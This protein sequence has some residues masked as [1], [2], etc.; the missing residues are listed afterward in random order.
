MQTFTDFKDDLSK[1]QDSILKAMKDPT[2]EDREE[3]AALADE[4]TQTGESI[5]EA[6]G[7]SH[8]ARARILDRERLIFGQMHPVNSFKGE[9]RNAEANKAFRAFLVKRGHDPNFLIP[10]VKTKPKGKAKAPKE[11]K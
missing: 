7:V 8:A 3:A 5:R 2:E 1:L 6:G 4:F 11:T 9:N 10:P